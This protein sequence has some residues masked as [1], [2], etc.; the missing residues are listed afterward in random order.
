M[1]DSRILLADDAETN[2][3][4]ASVTL[5]RAGYRVDEVSNGADAVTHVLTNEVDLVLMDLTMP[6]M[7]GCAAAEAIRQLPEPKGST[8]IVAYSAHR[9]STERDRCEGAGIDA[10]I[11]KPFK[12]DKLIQVV[13]DL[14]R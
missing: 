9:S 13:E 12:L 1:T 8:P 7:D 11:E 6:V 5:R 14:L 10:Y 3:M 4:V 2:R